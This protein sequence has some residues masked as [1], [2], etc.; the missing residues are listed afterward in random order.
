[1]VLSVDWRG[2]CVCFLLGMVTGVHSVWA[3]FRSRTIIMTTRWGVHMGW[4][5][6]RLLFVLSV[7]MILF[8][9]SLFLL[10]WPVFFFVLFFFNVYCFLPSCLWSHAGTLYE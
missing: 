1:M 4:G 9:S 8:C 6:W 3:G 5:D 10:R 2:C 7:C